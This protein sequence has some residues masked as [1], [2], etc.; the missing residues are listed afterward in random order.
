MFDQSARLL[1]AETRK[2]QSVRGTL[3]RVW[4]YYSNYRIA[5]LLV[6]IALI[7]S[8]YMQV[9]IPDLT[10]QIVDC[11]LSPYQVGTLGGNVEEGYL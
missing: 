6:A 11:Y 2:A 10:G 7:A 3:G 8:T 5:L 1:G 4:S 9:M